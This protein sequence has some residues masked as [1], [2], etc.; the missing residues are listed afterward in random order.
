MIVCR[1]GKPRAG[2]PSQK[3][4]DCRECL[5]AKMRQWHAAARAKRIVC[6]GCRASRPRRKFAHLCNE[7]FAKSAK[8]KHEYKNDWRRCDR[9]T[10]PEKYPT[11]SGKPYGMRRKQNLCRC[12]KPRLNDRQAWCRDCCRVYR[13]Q[14]DKTPRGRLGAVVASSRRRTR[15]ATNGGA[16][17][18]TE[19]AE[20]CVLLGN[21]CFYCGEARPLTIDHDIPL[22]LGGTNDISNIL[23]ACWPCNRAK[24]TMTAREYIAF[25]GDSR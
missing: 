25:R 1:C 5:N 22:S 7:C 6:H 9:A 14:W 12:G 23:P 20:K 21:V 15:T 13:K 3:G 2:F 17:T 24:H 11:S 10:H 16:F 19:F 18:A 4:N 8:A